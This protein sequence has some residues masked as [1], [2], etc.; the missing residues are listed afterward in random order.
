MAKIKET[1]K[2]N[3]EEENTKISKK[4][5]TSRI[6]TW[7]LLLVIILIGWS[8][9][10]NPQ[11]LSNIRDSL[12]PNKPDQEMVVAVKP[13][14]AVVDNTNYIM[15]E[16]AQL[17]G[18]IELIRDKM[19]Q[20]LDLETLNLLNQKFE[21][22]EKNNLNIIDS[23]AD[24]ATV[25]G[26]VNRM[27][28][29]EGKV[30]KLIRVTDESAL[31]LTSVMLVKDAAERGGKFEYEAEVLSQLSQD[32][33]QIR[34][35]VEIIVNASTKGIKT[36]AFIASSFEGV[37]NNILKK[38]K[39][40]FEKT[41]KDRVNSKLSEYVKIRRTGDKQ[42]EFEKDQDLVLARKMVLAEDFA[43]AVR[44][45]EKPENM[46]SF[47][48]DE[49][50]RNWIDMVKVKQEF[51]AAVSQIANNSLAVMKVSSIKKEISYD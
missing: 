23:K 39:A 10:R 42:P 38:Q 25:L 49:E 37:Y 2:D 28:K 24:V 13:V 47:G 7:F 12:F 8:I 15:Q 46:Q 30:E 11:G 32:N 35:S 18:E 27:D 48:K 31:T 33:N 9:W 21:A 34:E 45:L 22:L 6:F 19:S 17:R 29:L 41:W 44:I 50:L 3:R 26:M 40:D 43:E 4:S 36:N 5:M 20:E 16:I 1:K 51:N 14:E